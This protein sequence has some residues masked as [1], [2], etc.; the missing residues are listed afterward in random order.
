MR[1]LVIAAMLVVAACGSGPPTVPPTIH[2]PEPTRNPT[3]E[4]TVMPT[5]T[6]VPTAAAAPLV[7][8]GSGD[9]VEGPF[10]LAA[11][12]Y[13]LDWVIGGR[14][15]EECFV[16]LDLQTVPD[17][18]TVASTVSEMAPEGGTV[19]GAKTFDVA[20]GSFVMTVDGDDCDWTI[21]ATPLG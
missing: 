9:A 18:V 5:V 7:I 10:D 1:R 11:G 8:T 17:G 21:T 13:R 3:P 20:G 14:H 2:V 12:F 4:L 6:P 16:A 15:G 19:E